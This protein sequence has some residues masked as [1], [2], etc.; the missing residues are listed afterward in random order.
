MNLKE[1]TI[2]LLQKHHITLNQEYDQHFLVDEKIIEDMIKAAH[3]TDKDSILE[4]GPGIGNITNV[5]PTAKKKICV[6]IDEQFK[7]LLEKISDVEIIF[8]SIQ[9]FLRENKYFNK[10]IANIPYQ[11][12]ETLMQYLCTTRNV[13]YAVLI[14]PKKF[15]LRL[16]KHPIFSAFLSVTMLKE[17]PKEAFFPEPDANSALVV[18]MPTNEKD[19]NA[20]IRRELYLQRDKKLKNGLREVLIRVYPA[21]QLTKKQSTEIIK[22]T[23]IEQKLLDTKI[24]SMPLEEYTEITDKIEKAIV[25]LSI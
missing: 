18:I 21:K 14:L 12:S 23:E 20:L 9:I 16:E 6:E 1:K 17:V 22:K 15:A 8:K 11:V 2:E 5:L 7:P 25:N 13:E 3:I 4:I 24:E 10:I 19:H